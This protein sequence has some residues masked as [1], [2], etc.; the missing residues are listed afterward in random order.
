MYYVYPQDSSEYVQFLRESH[1]EALKEEERRYRFLAE[2][3]CGLIQS[4]ARLMNKV[5]QL[6]NST[7]ELN[8]LQFVELMGRNG[9]GLSHSSLR[10]QDDKKEE[11]AKYFMRMIND[12]VGLLKRVSPTEQQVQSQG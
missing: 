3:H 2:K 4:I 6:L 9:S 8:I 10:R 11:I 7:A 1:G 12:H 5:C